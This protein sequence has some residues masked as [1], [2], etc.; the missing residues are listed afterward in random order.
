MRVNTSASLIAIK[1]KRTKI[2]VKLHLFLPAGAGTGTPFSQCQ[3]KDH[4]ETPD[5]SHIIAI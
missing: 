4:T 3:R 5:L 1:P 2:S